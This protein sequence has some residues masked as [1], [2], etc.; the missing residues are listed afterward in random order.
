MPFLRTIR[1]KRGYETTYLMHW[2]R[3]GSRPRSRILYVFRTPG[4]IRVGREALDPDV[5]RTIEAQYP[6]IEFDWKAVVDNRQVVEPVPERRGR[7]RRRIEGEAA[8]A[9][10][11][12]SAESA[13]AQPPPAPGTPP[14][15]AIPSAIEGATPDEQIAFLMTWYPRVRN[16]IPQ[17]TADPVRQQ[18]LL[19]LAERLNPATWTDADQI[20]AGLQQA[21]EALE[22][23]SHV[24]AKRRRRGRRSS[25]AG[26]SA[27]AADPP[28]SES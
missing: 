25:A 28:S 17:R 8:P 5:L 9:A 15:P 23:L 11:A 24:F 14:R 13:Q 3:E 1:D 12:E 10:A 22:R 19:A 2:Y 27:A 26:R 7:K 20:A 18:A 21:A 6:D 4:G 16:R